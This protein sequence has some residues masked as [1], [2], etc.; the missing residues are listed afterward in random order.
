[1]HRQAVVVE[2]LGLAE[3]ADSLEDLRAPVPTR[4][5]PISQVLLVG[6]EGMSLR[7]PRSF[8]FRQYLS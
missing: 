8:I 6:V 2:F 3:E 1:M 5:M 4:N 7:A